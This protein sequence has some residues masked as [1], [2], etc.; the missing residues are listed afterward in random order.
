MGNWCDF[1]LLLGVITPVI[2]G[3]GA[4]FVGIEVEWW[5]EGKV[6][7]LMDYSYWIRLL[8]QS[9]R[10][11]VCDYCLAVLGFT[12]SLETKLQDSR[13]Y[14]LCLFLVHF[15][16]ERGNGVKLPDPADPSLIAECGRAFWQT[17]WRFANSG[18]LGLQMCGR[19]LSPSNLASS[20]WHSL[21]W[22]MLDEYEGDGARKCNLFVVVMMMVMV[23]VVVVMTSTCEI[24]RLTHDVWIMIYRLFWYMTLYDLGYINEWWLWWWLRQCILYTYN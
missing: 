11:P 15:E 10:G 3:S 9:F 1:I 13:F 14:E 23:V 19:L 5:P 20:I 7:P 8:W 6:V 24:S 12:A 2:T 22:E 17:S 16:T 4:H 21:P 18:P